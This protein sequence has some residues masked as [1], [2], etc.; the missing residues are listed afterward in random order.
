MRKTLLSIL[1]SVMLTTAAYSQQMEKGAN[2]ISAGVGLFSGFGANVA[3]D[4]GVIDE[5]G[6]GIFT[7]GGFIGGSSKSETG[8]NRNRW[9]F[10]PRAT[11]RYTLNDKVELY[12]AAMIGIR[13]TSYSNIDRSSTSGIDL[14]IAAGC[15]YNFGPNISGFAE[16][17]NNVN[18]LNVGI[19]FAF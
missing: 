12:G 9:F 18:L 11:Y 5:W 17:G 15:R 13:V 8:Y 2:L 14:A 1:M 4:Y 10:A 3:Y 6:P 16:M 19:S 7:V